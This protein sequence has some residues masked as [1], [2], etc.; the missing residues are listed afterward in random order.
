MSFSLLPFADL[1]KRAIPLT[2]SELFCGVK[3]PKYLIKED[4]KCCLYWTNMPKL[5]PEAVSFP[6]VYI[7]LLWKKLSMRNTAFCSISK[8]S[9]SGYSTWSTE[10]IRSQIIPRYF[11]IIV[12]YL[13]HLSW[14][15]S[16]AIQ[17]RRREGRN[18]WKWM[19]T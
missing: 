10:L 18:E 8:Y 4:I 15:E 6:L 1:Q 13:M 16:L 3:M 19:K 17:R 9:S 7:F 2:H 5:R 14:G 12:K 11:K